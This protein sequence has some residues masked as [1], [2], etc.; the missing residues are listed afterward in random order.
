MTDDK[1]MRD[2]FLEQTVAIATVP[3]EL[4][5]F[6]WQIA[7]RACASECARMCKDIAERHV[8]SGRYVSDVAEHS[9]FAAGQADGAEECATAICERFGVGG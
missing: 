1:L 9:V 2:D 8:C 4:K 5:W 7:I 6:I 3:R